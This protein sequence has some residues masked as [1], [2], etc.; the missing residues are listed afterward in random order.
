VWLTV[1]L[2]AAGI[3]GAWVLTETPEEAQTVRVETPVPSDTAPVPAAVS[4]DEL[5]RQQVDGRTFCEAPPVELTEEQKRSL[6]EILAKAPIPPTVPA[7]TPDAVINI[8]RR[9]VPC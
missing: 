9:V 4:I 3:G 1:F 7:D 6:D 8:H 5:I 2:V